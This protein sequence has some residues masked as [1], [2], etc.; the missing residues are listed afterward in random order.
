MFGAATVGIINSPYL[1]CGPWVIL[2][3]CRN[4]GN[5]LLFGSGVVAV[6]GLLVMSRF[7]PSVLLIGGR[8]LVIV[9]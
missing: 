7:F 6:R 8:S 5:R 3:V 4:M 2:V 1:V 9:R